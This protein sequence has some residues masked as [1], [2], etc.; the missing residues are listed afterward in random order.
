MRV[1]RLLEQALEALQSLREGT[2]LLGAVPEAGPQAAQ[3]GLSA[4]CDALMM[5]YIHI[6]TYYVVEAK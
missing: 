6:Y 5:T 2:L 1:L 3:E 4:C